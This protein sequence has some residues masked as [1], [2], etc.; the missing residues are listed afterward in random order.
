MMPIS[1]SEPVTPETHHRKDLSFRKVVIF[2]KMGAL[3]AGISK[4]VSFFDHKEY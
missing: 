3:I 2:L 1:R 4:N